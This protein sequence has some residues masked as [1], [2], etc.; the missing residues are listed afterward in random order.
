MDAGGKEGIYRGVSRGKGCSHYRGASQ[1]QTTVGELLLRLGPQ[2]QGEGMVL[3]DPGGVVT[4]DPLLVQ[5]EAGRKQLGY[6]RKSPDLSSF[7]PSTLP[8]ARGQGSPNSMVHRGQPSKAQ[9]RAVEAEQG[10][11]WSCKQR[12]CSWVSERWAHPMVTPWLWS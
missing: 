11:A 10:L 5:R 12:T 7:Q 1:G 2:E 8:L 4:L 9:S 6:G 3:S